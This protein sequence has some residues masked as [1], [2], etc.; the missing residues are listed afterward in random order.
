MER[1]RIDRR[2]RRQRLLLFTPQ[3]LRQ[4]SCSTSATASITIAITTSSAVCLHSWF[5]CIYGA[6]R[7]ADDEACTDHLGGTASESHCTAEATGPRQHSRCTSVTVV[8][9]SVGT[10]GGSHT[11][12]CASSQYTTLR[13][14][15]FGAA[16]RCNPVFK[17]LIQ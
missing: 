16:Y 2:D 9:A 15:S 14:A 11:S 12:T 4:L 1:D 5:R 13:S 17:T 3:P 7:E 10:F 8:A 6:R